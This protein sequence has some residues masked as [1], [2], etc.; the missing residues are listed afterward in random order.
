MVSKGRKVSEALLTAERSASK[1]A[2]SLSKKRSLVLATGH[3]EKHTAMTRQYD[4]SINLEEQTNREK[5]K[6]VILA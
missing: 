2:Q 6:C 3:F 1:K 5:K 4:C